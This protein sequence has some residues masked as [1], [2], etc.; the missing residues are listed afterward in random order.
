MDTQG[1]KGR[2]LIR[3]TARQEGGLSSL[4]VFEFCDDRSSRQKHTVA[5]TT[6]WD[7]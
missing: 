6:T 5:A 3:W 2:I 1:Q 7:S 4:T